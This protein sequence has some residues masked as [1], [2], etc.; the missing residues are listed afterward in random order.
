MLLEFTK[1]GDRISYN[2][3]FKNP[4]NLVDVLLSNLGFDAMR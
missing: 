4:F 2:V 3:F 1:S